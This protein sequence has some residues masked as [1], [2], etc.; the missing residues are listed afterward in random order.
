MKIHR[1]ETDIKCDTYGKEFR[2]KGT[3]GAYT[4]F[5]PDMKHMFYDKGSP[6][7]IHMTT[8]LLIRTKERP[9]N[10]ERCKKKYE[11]YSRLEEA[12]ENK[13]V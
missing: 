10:C 1:N 2:S 8:H 3:S 7:S 9:W 6:R 13:Q 5:Q 12:S 4:K 11:N